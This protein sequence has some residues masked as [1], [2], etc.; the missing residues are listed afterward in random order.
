MLKKIPH[1][2]VIIFILIIFC[3][4]STWFIPGGEF[5]REQVIVNNVEREVIKAGSFTVT[6]S[7]PQTWQVFSAFFDGFV[8][9]A[10]IIAFILMIGGAFWIL[11]ESK[12][13]D[14]GIF[15]FLKFTKKL[16]SF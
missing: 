12:S 8:N 16:E 4:V 2:Y 9:T 10:H 14:I 13:I 5:Q 6:E 1:S 7:N 11:N 3:A 15:S